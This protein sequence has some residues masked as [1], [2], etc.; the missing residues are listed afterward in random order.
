MASELIIN[1]IQRHKH[2]EP[3]GI[4]SVCSAN[5]YVLQ[6]AMVQAKADDS[7]LLVESTSNQVDQ[8][9]GYSGMTPSQ[10]VLYVGAIAAEMGLNHGQ[11]I[12]GGDH[13]GPNVW[14]NESADSAM[15]K[16]R[17]QVS[18][19]IKAGYSKFHLDTTFRCAD[20]PPGPLAAETIAE[21]TAD[22]CQAIEK[23]RSPRHP[24]PVYVIGS[25]VPTP[26]GKTL[27]MA[28]I[29]VTPVIDVQEIIHLTQQVFLKRGLADAWKRVI[30]IVVQPGVEFDNEQIYG[31]ERN[32]ALDLKDF[33]EQDEQFVY[34]AHSTDYQTDEKLK[35]MVED[36]FT[37]LKVG[38]WLTFTFR[39]AV[40]ALAVIEKEFLGHR[41][42]VQLSEIMATVEGE[43]I[44]NPS[45]WQNHYQG[46]DAALALARKYG[47]SDRIRYYWAHPAIQTSLD[48]LFGNLIQNPLPLSMLSQYLPI[49]Y[50]ALRNGE[51]TISPIDL[52]THKIRQVL[53]K[54]ANATQSTLKN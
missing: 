23:S 31:Y 19:Y 26:G 24:A 38:P 7:P 17:E 22:L 6:A 34:E 11:L 8:F 14:Q 43:M 53:K 40:F 36:H 29:A 13:L 49:Q 4:Y 35:E 39:E 37:I 50:E 46:D 54:Y 2:G 44:K 25:D 9:G 3:V 5:R 52:V 10:F 30:A 1:I 21:R 27:G 20:D 16:A 45:Y 51:I 18:A 28:A 15:V 12:L 41:K 42:K 33:I 48:R 32:K 47:L